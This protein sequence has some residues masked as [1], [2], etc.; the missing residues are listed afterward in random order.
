MNKTFYI[1]S[2]KVKDNCVAYIEDL[3]EGYLVSIKNKAKSRSN[4]Q[5]RLK[6]MWMGFLAKNA[7]GTFKGLDSS[8]WNRYFKQLFLRGMLIEQDE[9]YIE[10]FTKIEALIEGSDDKEFAEK[11]VWDNTKTEWLTI[12]KMQRFLEE[13]DY[14]VTSELSLCLPIPDDLKWIKQRDDHI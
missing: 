12:K 9:K 2:Q 6:W 5:L 10:Y 14:S 11:V 13:I 8:G 4:A 7:R 1:V 3:P